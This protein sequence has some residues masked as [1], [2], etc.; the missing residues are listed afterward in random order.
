MLLPRS[1]ASLAKAR[2]QARRMNEAARVV[3]AE[4]GQHGHGDVVMDTSSGYENRSLAWH[5][6]DETRPTIGFRAR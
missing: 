2:Q 6:S 4:L 5:E 1:L 3:R